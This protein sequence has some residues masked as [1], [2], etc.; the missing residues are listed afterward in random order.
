MSVSEFRCSCIVLLQSCRYTVNLSFEEDSD[1]RPHLSHLTSV[2][3]IL[4]LKHIH[5]GRYRCTECD[6]CFQSSKDLARHGRIHSGEKPFRCSLCNR[7]FNRSDNFQLH[8]RRVHSSSRPHLC[9]Y[10]GKLFATGTDLNCHVQI[11]AKPY[12]CGHC[13]E[14][15][16]RL[17]QLKTHLLKSQDL[18]T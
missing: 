6:K 8:K 2:Q 7:S 17:Q 13:A 9:S 1:F 10:C 12:S 5:T 18:G 11:H 14:R 4:Q 16:T 3:F 15:F